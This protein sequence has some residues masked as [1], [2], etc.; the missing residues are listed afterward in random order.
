MKKILPLVIA[1]LMAVQVNVNALAFSVEQ[2]EQIGKIA[3]K[4]I[5]N[6]PEVL[7]KASETLQ[8]KQREH[9]QLIT[10]NTVMKHID[11][12]IKDKNT[13]Y[14]G[15]KEATVNVIEFFDYQCGYCAKISPVLKK[16][17]KENPSV[18]FIYKETPI[19]ANRWSSSEYAA[20]VG[21]WVFKQKGSQGYEQYHDGIYALNK[22]GGQL[23]KQ[24]INMVAKKTGINLTQMAGDE[25]INSTLTLFE[26]LGF[27]GTPALIVMPSKNVTK[28]SIHVIN[29]FD[30]QA[31][32]TAIQQVKS[33]L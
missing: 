16:L 7:I 5:I 19:F 23:T 2:Q 6:N 3:S 28:E 8:Q 25:T 10:K 1:V 20:Q 12:L 18:K 26:S 22:I 17:Q 11:A 15:P 32:S 9:Q 14:I 24:D 33:T 29:G 21:N 4:Y 31:L 13:P 30:P 27:Q